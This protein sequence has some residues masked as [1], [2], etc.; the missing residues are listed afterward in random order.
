MPD[1]AEYIMPFCTSHFLIDSLNSAV[2][3]E[4][5]SIKVILKTFINNFICNVNHLAWP[6][7]SPPTFITVEIGV[8]PVFSSRWK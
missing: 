5:W 1:M 6:D 3:G 2:L 7:P 8:A 4:N